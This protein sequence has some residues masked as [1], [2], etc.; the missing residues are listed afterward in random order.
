[1]CQHSPSSQGFMSTWRID[2]WELNVAWMAVASL[3]QVSGRF[4]A[5]THQGEGLQGILC[6]LRT[7]WKPFLEDNI[8][9]CSKNHSES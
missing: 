2:P 6:G 9:I 8:K 7:A 4:I 3:D 1:M 5:S